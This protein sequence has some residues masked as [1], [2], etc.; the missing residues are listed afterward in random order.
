MSQ[1]P[2]VK[3]TSETATSVK[4]REHKLKFTY[5]EQQEFNTIEDD[6]QA[7]EDRL[8]AI[9]KEMGLN[10]RDFVKLNQLT[11]EQKELNAQLEY[12]ME[13]WDYLMELDEKI[14]NQ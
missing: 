6:I 14:K 4:P 5:K 7:I 8:K 2:E 13:R 12:K 11:K 9:D 3:K 10:A 1:V